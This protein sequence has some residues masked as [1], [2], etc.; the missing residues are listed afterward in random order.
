MAAL[1]LLLRVA[2]A[3]N[4]FS[5]WTVAGT[6]ANGV[7]GR[8]VDG[9]GT[10]AV[11]MEPYNFV[12]SGNGTGYYFSEQ[13]GH[14]VRYLDIASVRVTTIAGSPNSTSGQTDGIGTGATLSVPEGL[15]LDTLRGVL[16]VT[17]FTCT[18]VRRINLTS[19]ATAT[20]LGSAGSGTVSVDGIGTNAVVYSNRGAAF[21]SPNNLLYMTAWSAASIRVYNASS[22]VIRTISGSTAGAVD[23]QGTAIRFYNPSGL[24]MTP[25]FLWVA[26]SYYGQF[27]KVAIAAP[28]VLG[29]STSILPPGQTFPS[30]W[31]RGLE[32][33]VVSTNSIYLAAYNTAAGSAV[34]QIRLSDPNNRTRLGGDPA[35][36]ATASIDGLG[37]AARFNGLLGAAYYIPTATL[38]LGEFVGLRIRAMCLA[39]CSASASPAA[40]AT[41]SATVSASAPPSASLSPGASASATATFTSTASASPSSPASSSASATRSSAPTPAESPASTPLPASASVS[42]SAA[43]AAAASAALSATASLPATSTS[44][45]S[46]SGVAVDAAAAAAATAAGTAAIAGGVGAVAT[47]A[48]AAAAALLILLLRT[49]RRLRRVL[50]AAPAKA[51]GD[52]DGAA[53]G[54]AN[55]LRGVSFRAQAAAAAVSAPSA[56]DAWRPQPPRQP[57]LPPPSALLPPATLPPGWTQH[58]SASQGRAYWRNARGMTSWERPVAE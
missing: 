41:A 43:A 48:I 34:F 46:S 38:Y 8:V 56:R 44:S 10:S 36:A 55:P 52:G 20:V 30:G 53:T 49:R 17:C 14:R 2:V 35:A 58:V 42:A 1:L 21:D 24:K 12:L 5:T 26:E 7:A 39:N 37:T 47:L 54:S 4:E 3:V 6:G 33:D 51:G 11:C 13:T 40:T 9:I 18:T 16:Y 22:G 25:G 29:T 31:L 27:R 45:V 15:G 19:L 57:E 32:V 28:G 23:G 50:A